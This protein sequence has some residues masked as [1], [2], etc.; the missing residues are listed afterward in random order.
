M[1]TEKV[2]VGFELDAGE[3]SDGVRVALGELGASGDFG[4]EI[5]SDEPVTLTYKASSSGDD[6]ATPAE[7][8]DS[9]DGLLC[10]HPGGSVMYWP[11]VMPA[12]SIWVYAAAPAGGDG[13]TV[14][15]TLNIW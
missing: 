9:V 10:E 4:L 6:D 2:F 5:T 3:T 7:L 8:D 1:V 12:A 11:A 13:A 15:A 14:S